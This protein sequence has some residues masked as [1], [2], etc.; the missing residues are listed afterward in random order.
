MTKRDQLIKS[1]HCSSALIVLAEQMMVKH[2]RQLRNYSKVDRP[3]IGARIGKSL[4]AFLGLVHS[5]MKKFKKETTLRDADAELA[6]LHSL[7]YVA[8][9]QKAI[10]A[11]QTAEWM[12]LL[13]TAG[14]MLGGWI[15]QSKEN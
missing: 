2:D 10:S 6:K 9:E 12:E 3:N 11:G 15:K 13:D 5:A 8:F 14:K 7:I 1:P 4:D